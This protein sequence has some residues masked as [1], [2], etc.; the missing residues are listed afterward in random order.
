MRVEWTEWR[1][2]TWFRIIGDLTE[3]GWEFWD[4]EIWDIRWYP[5]IATAELVATAR[6]IALAREVVARQGKPSAA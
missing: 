6:A 3:N 4:K 5:R 2:Q 1:D